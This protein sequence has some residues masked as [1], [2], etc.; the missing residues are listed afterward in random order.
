MFRIGDRIQP[1]EEGLKTFRNWKGRQG[2]IV[3]RTRSEENVWQVKWDGRQKVEN[4]HETFITQL[5]IDPQL[6]S[7]RTGTD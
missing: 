6:T 1:S 2:T 4:I 7:R 5:R 3:G